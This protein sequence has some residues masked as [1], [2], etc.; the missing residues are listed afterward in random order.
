MRHKKRMAF[1]MSFSCLYMSGLEHMA[2]R[3]LALADTLPSLSLSY[4]L[5]WEPP[6]Y[7]SIRRVAV[8]GTP[9]CASVIMPFAVSSAS[10][11]IEGAWVNQLE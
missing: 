11:S 4:V 8:I 6:P 2:D 7:L 3:A 5:K 1:S 9:S 10:A